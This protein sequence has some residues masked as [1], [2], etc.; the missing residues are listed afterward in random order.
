MAGERRRRDAFL[1]PVDPHDG[2][3]P[4]DHSLWI[5]RNGARCLLVDTGFGPEAAARRGRVLAHDPVA[6]PA[7][8]GLAADSIT[9]IVLSHLHQDHAGSIAAFPTARIPVQDEEVA[10]ATGRCI[11]DDLLRFP[12]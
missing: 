12:F 6:A 5:L 9:D 2:P 3:M 8:I 11:C 10:H 1:L 7:R 4:M